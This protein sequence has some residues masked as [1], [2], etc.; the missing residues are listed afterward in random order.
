MNGDNLAP[1]IKYLLINDVNVLDVRVFL[2]SFF[3]FFVNWY[4]F[5]VR[6]KKV[7][8]IVVSCINAIP[9]L[10]SM[11]IYFSNAFQCNSATW[12]LIVYK[13]LSFYFFYL[14]QAF[15]KCNLIRYTRSVVGVVLAVV[16]STFFRFILIFVCFFRK[17][18][19]KRN[20]TVEKANKKHRRKRRKRI[21][22]LDC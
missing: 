9:I 15:F 20:E 2:L 14:F 18:K 13:S 4:T 1:L 3:R 19:K 8:G 6:R 22:L 5:I 7:S 16:I 10:I 12:S 21:S 17:E 11:A